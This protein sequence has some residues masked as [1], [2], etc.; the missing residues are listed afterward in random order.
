MQQIV[1]FID[2][3]WQHLS[4]IDIY[5]KNNPVAPSKL[6]TINNITSLRILVYIIYIVVAST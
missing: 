6:R 5:S 1:Q 4:E 2:F 3:G